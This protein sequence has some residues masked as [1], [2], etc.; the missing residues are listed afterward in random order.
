[1]LSHNSGGGDRCIWNNGGIMIIRGKTHK[2]GEE[3]NPVPIR[4]SPIA[5]EVI[6]D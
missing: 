6:Q 3:I 4:L 5:H 1:M 2:F